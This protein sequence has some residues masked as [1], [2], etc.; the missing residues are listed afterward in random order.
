MYQIA[1]QPK[2]NAADRVFP[3]RRGDIMLL[4]N[5][6]PVIHIELKKSDIDV[7][8]A[9][10][11]IEKYSKEGIFTGIF[12]LV[13]VFVAMTPEETLYFGNIYGLYKTILFPLG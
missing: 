2:F 12:A 4:I 8:Q 1:Q 9:A 6:M 5:G 7:T 11:Q 3:K 10:N 13:Q